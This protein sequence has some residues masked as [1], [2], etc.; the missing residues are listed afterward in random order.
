MK[1]DQNS[2]LYL[3][4]PYSSP[5]PNIEWERYKKTC[6]AAARLMASGVAV[7]SPL[8]NSIPAV[9][10][11]GLDID[12]AAFLRIDKTI[13]ARC[14]ELMVLALDGWRESKGVQM[15]VAEAIRLHL[16]IILV[17]EDEIDS[18]PVLSKDSCFFKQS[19]I[20]SYGT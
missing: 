11:G 5:D 6:G 2:V 9:H 16:P 13:L 8:A 18:L 3:A 10:L 19:S 4:A 20:L 7:F 1:P 17:R 12:H 15:E 14:D